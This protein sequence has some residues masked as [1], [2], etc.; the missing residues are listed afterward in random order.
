MKIIL[1]ERIK[2]VGILGDEVN[3]AAGFARNFLIPSGKAMRVTEANKLYFE[4]QRTQ[5]EK[6][7]KLT[8]ATAQ[9]RSE[10]LAQLDVQI[11]ARASQEGRLYGSIGT[12]QIATAIAEAGA[13]VQAS[14]VVLNEGALR[15][16]GEHQVYLQLH[17][18]VG[19]SVK[20][21]ISPF[22]E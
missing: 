9:A 7:A 21:R 2:K 11:N 16:I 4:S 13:T 12:R 1:L 3:V 5:L 19:V 17:P 14:E 10:Q 6:E 8:Q 22:S 20:I 15:E 18:E